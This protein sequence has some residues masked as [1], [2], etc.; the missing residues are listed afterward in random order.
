MRFPKGNIFKKFWPEGLRERVLFCMLLI[1]LLPL[2]LVSFLDYRDASRSINEATREHLSSVLL[3]R[4][5]AS[6]GWFRERREDTSRFVSL[7]ALVFD[8]VPAEDRERQSLR[9]YIF[10]ILHAYQ[11]E[12]TSLQDLRLYDAKWDLIACSSSHVHSD[13]DTLGHWF[14]EAVENQDGPYFDIEHLRDASDFVRHIGAKVI[15]GEGDCVGFLV[16]NLD[17]GKSL[18]RILHDRSGLHETGKVYVVSLHGLV[19]SSLDSEKHQMYDAQEL[20]KVIYRNTA[21]NPLTLSKYRDFFGETVLGTSTLLSFKNWVLVAEIDYLEATSQIRGLVLR[22]VVVVVMALVIVVLLALRASEYMARPL[23]ELARV[24]H[25]VGEGDLEERVAL[26]SGT[27]AIEVREAFNLMLDELKSKQR[28]LAHAAVLA[29]V[30][31]LTSSIAHEMRNPLS[32][33]RMNLQALQG[34]TED[35]IH[36]KELGMIAAEQ[37][38]RVEAMLSALLRYGRHLKIDVAPT[39]AADLLKVCFEVM[40]ASA[41]EKGVKVIV[42][43]DLNGALLLIDK[44]QITQAL[45]NLMHNAIQASPPG[46]EVRVVLSLS[47]SQRLFAEIAVTDHGPGLSRE[48]ASRVFQP[49]FTTKPEGMGLGLAHVKKIIELHGGDVHVVNGTEDGAIFKV[50]IP[51]A[52]ESDIEEACK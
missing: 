43:D 41:Q 36:F 34:A 15:N 35:D 17:L 18:A 14:K 39:S 19:L 33:I 20:R 40:A 16:A 42:E 37:L 44:E 29:S 8:R 21:E 27:E 28:E 25:R 10:D 46:R 7:L 26:I 12:T 52:Y 31:E 49:F 13:S 23:K 22:F 5:H 6:E 47:T 50:S 4:K 51:V 1:S 2:C 11:E 30:G 24:A 3:S 9:E 38:A 45:C 48:V 32:S